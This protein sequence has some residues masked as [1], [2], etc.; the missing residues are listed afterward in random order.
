MPARLIAGL[1][2]DNLFQLQRLLI[3]F[4][5]TH[6]PAQRGQ[7]TFALD[8]FLTQME[9]ILAEGTDKSSVIFDVTALASDPADPIALRL[10]KWRKRLQHHH[11]PNT[12]C[13]RGRAPFSIGC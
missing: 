12:P 5:E 11:R 7:L 10:F 4:R 3:H 9:A 8:Q 1:Q 13:Q 6:L 2:S